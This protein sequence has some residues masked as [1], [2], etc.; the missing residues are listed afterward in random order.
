VQSNAELE[1]FA[2]IASH[3]LQEP[4]RMV[5]NFTQL[6]NEEYGSQFGEEAREYMKFIVGGA[7]RMQ[8]LVSDLLEYSR[9]DKDDLVM[10]HVECDSVMRA[11]E[12]NLKQAIQDS[13]ARIYYEHLPVVWANPIQLMRLLQNLVGNA[14]KYRKAG[15][16]PDILVEVV[17]GQ[18]GCLFSV[19]DNGIGI[20]AEYLD[21]VFVLF[22]RL[23]RSSEYQGSGIGLSICKKIVESMG[24]EIWVESEYGQGSTFYFTLP[25]A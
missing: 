2:Y 10:Q 19:T 23:H 12:E 6:L 8:V 1:R 14:L 15:V 22:K 3:D 16:K 13:G 18:D 21:Q 25:R 7:T 9:V 24:G 11:V 17:V 4:L 20:K 5:R